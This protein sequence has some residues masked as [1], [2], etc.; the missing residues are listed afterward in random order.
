LISIAT[1]LQRTERAIQDIRRNPG[2]T[3]LL[4]DSSGFRVPDQR[5]EISGSRAANSTDEFEGFHEESHGIGPAPIM[6]RTPAARAATYG[7]G[8][9]EKATFDVSNIT[10]IRFSSN[11]LA[12]L[13]HLGM[14]LHL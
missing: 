2:A 7:E 1:T 4:P 11:A 6:C 12:D 8:T 14:F 5:T 9:K 3:L 13:L 10:A